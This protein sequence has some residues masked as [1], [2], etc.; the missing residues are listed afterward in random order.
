PLYCAIGS[1]TVAFASEIPPLFDLGVEAKPDVRGVSTYLTTIRTVVGARTMY[2][3]VRALRPGERLTIDLRGSRP[4]VTSRVQSL[5]PSSC[6]STVEVVEDAIE[7]HLRSDVPLCCLLSGGLDSSIIVRETTRRVDGVRTFCAGA[8]SET[9]DDDFEHAR[10]VAGA[11]GTTHTEC[12]VSRETF[13]R[14]V[15]EM[16][17][18]LGVPLSTPNE[19]AIRAVARTLRDAGAVVALSGEGADEVFGGYDAPLAM[20]AAHVAGGNADPGC[21]QLVANAWMSPAD[22]PRFLDERFWSAVEHDESLVTSYREIWKGHERNEGLA[23]HLRFQRAVNLSGLLQ[24]LDTATMLASVE[25]RTPF[26]DLVVVAHAESLPMSSRY[27][28]SRTKIALRDG[29]RSS[30]PERVVERPKASFPLPFQ[31]WLHGFASDLRSSSFLRSVVRPEVV[32]A[33]AADP[34]SN[35]NLAWPM[36]NLALWGARFE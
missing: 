31:G 35:W 1:D 22:K 27:D 21:F 7:R 10:L 15:P 12:V 3:G 26:A 19:V 2:E 20:A 6:G 36:V 16:I 11:L 24:R 23:D 5:A 25:G 32:D 28:G 8:I 4:V 30:L 29:W 18:S 34:A 17:G 33:V 14:E 13:L 9:G